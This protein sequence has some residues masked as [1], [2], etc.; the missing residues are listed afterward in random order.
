[1]TIGQRD[2]DA[3]PAFIEFFTRPFTRFE[4]HYPE[5]ASDYDWLRNSIYLNG[6]TT[7]DLS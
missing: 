2:M 3:K 4:F 1:M 6:W 5:Q 7:I